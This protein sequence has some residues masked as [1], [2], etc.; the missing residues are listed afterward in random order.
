MQERGA[1][2]PAINIIGNGGYVLPGFSGSAASTMTV[3]VDHLTELTALVRNS[4]N[5]SLVDVL[6]IVWM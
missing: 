1:A 3:Q 4:Y 2:G 5:G 6:N